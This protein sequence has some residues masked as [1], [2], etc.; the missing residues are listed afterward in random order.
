MPVFTERFRPK[1]LD[2][3]IGQDYNVGVLKGFTQAPIEEVPHF[4]FIGRPGTGK[5]TVARAFAHDLGLEDDMDDSDASKNRKVDY[6]RDVFIPYCHV[7]PSNPSNHK[8][9]FVFLDEF[10]LMTF[11]AQGTLRRVMETTSSINIFVFSANYP[12]KIIPAIVSR[13]TVLKFLPL[14]ADTLVAMGKKILKELK[15]DKI[16][17]ADLFDLAK[18]SQGDARK[19]TDLLSQRMVGG[20]LPPDG[21]DLDKYLTCLKND[22]FE[23]AK[24]MLWGITYDDLARSLITRWAENSIPSKT[25]LDLMNA[26]ASAM[27]SNPQ[28]DDY[29]GKIWITGF[30]LDQMRKIKEAHR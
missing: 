24:Q 9:K 6:I 30:I 1:T 19:F 25:V 15:N 5:T 2:E 13:C 11:E 23:S 27:I 3:V 28:P 10:D 12:H 18:R 17:E 4:M 20:S 22:D 7:M 21:I 26:V 8:R 16:P 29:I 14:S